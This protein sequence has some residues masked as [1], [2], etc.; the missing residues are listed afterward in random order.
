MPGHTL[1]I[2][3]A[4]VTCT[5]GFSI[6]LFAQI[7]ICAHLF[8]LLVP[9]LGTQGAGFAAG[10]ASGFAKACAVA[11]R[12]PVGWFLPPAMDR[13]FAAALTYLV[14][15]RGCLDFVLAGGASVALLLL[16]VFLFGVGISNVTSL[17]PLIAQTE[18]APADIPRAIA[19]ATAMAQATFA[20]APALFGLL[21]EWE[22][23]PDTTATTLF[24]LIAGAIQI[25]A[26]AFYTTGRR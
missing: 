16:G 1:W 13:R 9:A 23:A 14:Q 17:P 3:R 22:A 18:F 8:S 12:S 7:G 21:R 5:V 11:G 2:N 20:F 26:A 19:L 15:T 4:F 24:F 10:F 25:A 6:V